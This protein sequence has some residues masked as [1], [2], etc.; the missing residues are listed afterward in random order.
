MSIGSAGAIIG[1][2]DLQVGV[3]LESATDFQRLGP[4]DQLWNEL[5]GRTDE[6]S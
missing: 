6:D 5:L 4:L 1:Q 3:L 2:D